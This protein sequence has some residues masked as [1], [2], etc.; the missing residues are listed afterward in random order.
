M[1]TEGGVPATDAFFATGKYS[2]FFERRNTVF[3]R[4]DH[5]LI[6][7][8]CNPFR[9]LRTVACLTDCLWATSRRL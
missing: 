9:M 5:A 4:P 8:S 6:P 7:A 2:A 3:V 1:N